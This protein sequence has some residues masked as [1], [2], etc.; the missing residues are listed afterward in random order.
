[1]A[2]APLGRGRRPRFIGASSAA[3]SIPRVDR[4]AILELYARCGS[5]PPDD[6]NVGALQHAWQCA[7]L[8]RQAGASPALQLAG[9]LHELG[10]LAVCEPTADGAAPGLAAEARAEA[11]LQPLFGPGVARPVA[12]LAQAR[13]CLAST[14]PDFRKALPPPAQRALEDDGG[15][16]SP[17]EAR[18]FLQL[19]YAPQALRLCL[20]DQASCDPRL[21]PPSP[22]GALDTLRRLMWLL[23]SATPLRTVAAAPAQQRVPATAARARPAAV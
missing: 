22:A 19:P 20:W 12:L 9:W 7:R 5:Q 3:G 15:L 6:G 8:A 11:W 17:V 4:Q 2:H 21:H 1:V 23:G 16:L 18:A 14:K 10:S 13:R